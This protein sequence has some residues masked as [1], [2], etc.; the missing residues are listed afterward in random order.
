MPTFYLKTLASGQNSLILEPGEALVYPFEFDNW[1]E[2]RL[3]A[4]I[5]VTTIDSDNKRGI[6][7]SIDSQFIPKLIFWFG[8]KDNSE[9]LPY[10]SGSLFAGFSSAVLDGGTEKITQIADN[11]SIIQGNFNSCVSLD[12][13]RV[14]HYALAGSRFYLYTDT[15]NLSTGFAGYN[16]VSLKRTN[17]YSGVMTFRGIGG[18]YTD[19]S[20]DNLRKVNRSFTETYTIPGNS[21][22]GYF[23]P[24]L[25]SF[26]IWSPFTLNRIRIHSLLIEQLA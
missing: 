20:L 24:S 16:S 12:G 7:E 1:Q 5:S 9:I 15:A 21:C 23:P 22:T 25:N 17:I 18:A 10:S 8:A 2:L 3:S 19:V 11:A 14:V 6:S 13:T 4:F 26:F